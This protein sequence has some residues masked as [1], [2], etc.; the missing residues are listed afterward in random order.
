M[1]A[2]LIKDQQNEQKQMKPNDNSNQNNSVE[3][4]LF[5]HR[6]GRLPDR[7]AT[8]SQDFDRRCQDL[9]AAE[10]ALAGLDAEIEEIESSPVPDVIALDPLY[11]R[12]S[13][14][15]AKIHRLGLE[16]LAAYLAMVAKMNGGGA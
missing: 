13:A 11:D 9:A 16:R 4:Q 6:V 7:P 14:T 5:P 2:P 8:A 12:H 10:S 15:Q 1:K 3:P